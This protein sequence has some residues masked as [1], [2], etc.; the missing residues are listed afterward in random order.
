MVWGIRFC[1]KIKAFI[2]LLDRSSEDFA[3]ILF[4]NSKD[5]GRERTFGYQNTRLCV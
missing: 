5:E 4:R 3:L 2:S 1:V